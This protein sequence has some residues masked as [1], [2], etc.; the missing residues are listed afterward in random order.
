MTDKLKIIFMGTPDFAVPTLQALIDSPHEVIAVYSQPPRPK[1]RGQKL[2]QSPVHELAAAHGIPVYTP[3]SLKTPEAK[4][5]FQALHADVTVVAAYGLILPEAVL[6]APRYGCLNIHASLLPRWR[7]AAPIQY[8]IWHGDKESGVTIMQMER[9]LDTGPM[10][11]KTKTPITPE[12]TTEILHDQLAAAGA[13]LL[14][15]VLENIESMTAE[16]QDESASTYAAMLKKE[17]G[18]I[19]WN[20]TAAKIDRQV[21]ALNPWPGTYTEFNGQRLKIL[22]TKIITCH[23]EALALKDLADT[24]V[25]PSGIRLQDDNI[26][27]LNKKGDV[28]CGNGTVLQILTLQPEGKKAMDFASALNG[29]YVKL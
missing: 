9:G 19:D 14:L 26:K 25:D 24:R 18:R 29:G 22:K 5:E 7:G 8:A 12:T 21:R 13:K 28:A 15:D 20:K 10:I 4:A 23:P 3:M 1:G 6:S 17:D 2:Q 16:A 11:A 27:V